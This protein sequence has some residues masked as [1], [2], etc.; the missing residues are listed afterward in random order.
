M[1]RPT[2]HASGTATL[3]SR[4]QLTIPA[5]VAKRVGLKRGDRLLLAVDRQGRV[6]GTPVRD[7]VEQLAGSLGRPSRR[8]RNA[9]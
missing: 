2:D 8:R 7:L 6:V 9:G 3:T 5:A 4:N 1:S